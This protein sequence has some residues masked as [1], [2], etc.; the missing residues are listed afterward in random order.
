MHTRCITLRCLTSIQTLHLSGVIIYEYYILH[1]HL[2]TIFAFTFYIYTYDIYI[3]I[4][5][6]TITIFV[7]I[8]YTAFESV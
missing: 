4:F 8:I 5:E 2:I 6:Y 7:F 3:Y 1:V